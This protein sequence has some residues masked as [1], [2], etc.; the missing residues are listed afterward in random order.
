MT[1]TM[2][3][4]LEGVNHVTL[5]NEAE[6]VPLISDADGDCVSG[7]RITLDTVVSAFGDG[8]TR[9]GDRAAASSLRLGDVYAILTFYIR[10]RPDID[11]YVR[12]RRRDA[13][14]AREE[15]ESRF[16]PEG[17]RER[18]LARR[19]EPRPVPHAQ[20]ARWTQNL[21]NDI[22][23]ALLR[24]SPSLDIV[25]VQDVGLSGA[26]IQPCRRGSAT[27]P[28]PAYPYVA[29]LTRYA[30]QRGPAWSGNA[31]RVRN[32]PR[33]P[34]GQAVEDVLLLA[35]CSREY[36]WEGVRYLPLR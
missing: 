14:S 36:E 29:S 5:K 30:Y 25:R 1:G 22:V 9:R 6:P 28:S 33:S 7:T 8:A 32:R 2:T 16:D 10:R 21:N 26:D 23:R 3:T 4:G 24:R 17:I 11:V 12:Q 13:E 35:E 18:L 19:V 15:N 20:A 34:I 27:Q 31:R